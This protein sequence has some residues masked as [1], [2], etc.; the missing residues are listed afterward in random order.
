M[1]EFSRKDGRSLHC[2]IKHITLPD[3]EIKCFV[4]ILFMKLYIG[5]NHLP[6]KVV[7]VSVVTSGYHICSN[8]RITLV[9]NSKILWS[10]YLLVG[11]KDY[12]K[13]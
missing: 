1:T 6:K 13:P 10:N 12:M 11:K 8:V 7:T 5:K 9:E 4:S 2:I 3:E